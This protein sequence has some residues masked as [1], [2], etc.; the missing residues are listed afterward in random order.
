[1][2]R[3]IAVLLLVP[4][5]ALAQEASLELEDC[6][7]SAGPAF[8]GIN[9]RCATLTRPE[10]PDAPDGTTITLKI[11]VVPALDLDPMPDPVLPIAGGPGQSTI[12]MYAT[13]RRAFEPLRR[14]RDILLIDQR[15][16]GD[17]SPMTCPV[18]TD[19]DVSTVSDEDVLA[20]TGECLDQLP[21]DPRYF[22]T[23]VAV[24]DIEA[25]RVALGYPAL[26][27]YGVSYG[28]RVAQH[29]ARRYPETTRT[30]I[31]DGV[32]PPDLPL[33]PDIALESQRAVDQLFARCAE[34]IA[35]VGAFPQLE[36]EFNILVADLKDNPRSVKM[37]HPVTGRPDEVT[38][39]HNELASA[40]RL[41]L[42]QPDSLA[43]LPLMIHNAANGNDIPITA[44]MQMVVGSLSDALAMG[45]HNSVMCTE[46]APFYE[47]LD[48]DAS[49]LDD[50]YMGGTQYKAL[51]LMCSVWPAGF[52]DEDLRENL[53]IDVPV[54]ALSGDVD[55]ITPP[56]YAARAI[57][58]LP[59]TR[60][61]IGVNQGHGQV[62]VSCMPQLLADFV[63]SA[64]V[65]SV[66]EECFQ[67]RTHVMPFFIDS[68]GPAK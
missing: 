48:F 22:T 65:E 27:I 2:I 13:Q 51:Q 8:Q 58:A 11:A 43:M 63:E 12:Q 19:L 30:V 35:C 4:A 56:E 34:D 23:S 1:M 32:V 39:G 33:G 10:N 36:E 64:D 26:N 5:L 28:S 53:S 46:D 52:L 16:T 18:D 20:L 61:I 45:M 41:L 3:W 62:A 57:S 38:L 42:Y 59:N 9:A 17:S 40:V 29:Y 49:R 21:H 68:T 14:T 6:R 44:S 25:V 55:P 54:L 47:A 67:T 31:I 50:T 15:G 24:R 66:D 37:L 7:I 60:H